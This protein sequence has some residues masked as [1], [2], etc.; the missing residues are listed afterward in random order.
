MAS[1]RPPVVAT[2]SYAEGLPPVDVD[3]NRHATSWLWEQ[4]ESG[5]GRPVV[6][7]PAREG[8]VALDK[9]EVAS[10]VS[11]LASGLIAAGMAAGDRVALMGATGWEWALADLAILAAAGVTVP[12]YDSSPVP[13]C[14]RILADSS[15]RLA[16]GGSPRQAARLREAWGDEGGPVVC[17]D[18]GGLDE[19]AEGGR[20][21]DRDELHRRLTY[22]DG[23][24]LA[25]IVYTSG[26]TGAPK[27]CRITH[28]NIV[29]TSTQARARLA[30]VVAPGSST[31][32]FLPLA[33]IFARVIQLTCFDAGVEVGYARS[34]SHLRDDLATFRPTFVLVVPEVLQRVFDRARRHARGPV[35]ALAFAFAERTGEDWAAVE[36]PGVRLR[37][38]RALAGA[39]VYSRLRA[40]LGGRVRFCVSGG[41]SLP[42]RLARFFQ[43]AGVTVL[44]GYGLTETTAPATVNAPGACRLGTVGQPLPGVA[45]RLTADGEVL[46]RGGNVFAGYHRD[47]EATAAAFEDGWF[48]TGDLGRLDGEGF[49]T[50]TGRKKEV[51]VTATGKMVAP[52]P[53]ED[54]LRAHPL[55]AEAMVVGDGR[56]YLGALVTLDEEEVESYFRA[57]GGVPTDGAP[58]RDEGIRSEIGR[59]LE[60]AN[61][62]VS[63]AESVRR[64]VI[65]DRRFSEDLGEL[66][67]SLKLRRSEIAEHFRDDIESLYHR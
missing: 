61:E 65:L 47:Q 45:V 17:I 4:S 52:A 15:P 33:H 6:R 31:L 1:R 64:F 40:G 56:P 32:L 34:L 57:Q 62:D 20:E 53:F 35:R 63:P 37:S 19:L 36:H 8:W 3:P 43:A 51:I 9:A 58:A 24:S 18:A 59:A 67:P 12:I 49:L 60:R 42:P 30:E 23:N 14:A 21:H 2:A 44:E 16:I 38:R 28:A 22:L 39:L 13:Q 7:Y 5:E 48:R 10:R 25:T 46:V 66:T 50:I 55:V 54:S 41:A 27:G 11:G 26:T 29:W